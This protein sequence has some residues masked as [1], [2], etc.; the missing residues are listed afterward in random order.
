[1]AGRYR[2]D[3]V[4]FRSLSSKQLEHV[5]AS[6]ALFRGLIGHRISDGPSGS[7]GL[8]K[9]RCPA[10]IPTIPTTISS[11]APLICASSTIATVIPISLR[12]T[13][14]DRN[15]STPIY[16]AANPY[17]VKHWPISRGSLSRPLN[18][19]PP[20]VAS[21]TSLFFRLRTASR[22]LP[23]P[24]ASASS[25]SLFVRLNTVPDRKP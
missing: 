20:I 24:S 9:G 12:P 23:N 5:L 18:H 6:F 21:G 17:Q 19:H 11:P 1:M 15:G 13:M 22:A 25:D 16:S 14:P 3:H 8:P 10:P 7:A 2:A 4:G